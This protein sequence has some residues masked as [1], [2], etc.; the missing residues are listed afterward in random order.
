MFG[1]GKF[2][3]TVGSAGQSTGMSKPGHSPGC[4][5][6]GKIKNGTICCWHPDQCVS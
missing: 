5:A 6:F 4:P 1:I 2:Y 3:N